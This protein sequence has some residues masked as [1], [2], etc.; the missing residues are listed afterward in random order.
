MVRT[1][2]EKLR[3]TRRPRARGGANMSG[4]ASISAGVTRLTFSE[5][6]VAKSGPVHNLGELFGYLV[7][8]E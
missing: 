3:R 5:D 7:E 8:V 2:G 4:F 1:F 6:E